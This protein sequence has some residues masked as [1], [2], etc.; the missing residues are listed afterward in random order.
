MAAAVVA[1]AVLG[2]TLAG[3]AAHAA[4]PSGGTVIRNVA[5]A[6]Y[7][8]AG[9]S[10]TETS[11]SNGVSATVLPVEALVL[12]QDQ[13]VSRPP[14]A[15]VTLSHLLAN[16][17]NVPSSYTIGLANGGAGCPAGALDMSALRVVRDTNNN[18][19]ADAADPVLP[20]GAG[21]AIAL[22]SGETA[23]LLVQG[24]VP[25]AASGNACVALT[26][27]TALQKL[28]AVNRDTVTVGDAAV[29]AITKSAS[30]PGFV[31]PGTTRIDFTGVVPV[32]LPAAKEMPSSRA[33]FSITGRLAP[34]LVTIQV[35]S[36]LRDTL[37]PALS[38]RF[39][40]MN[41]SLVAPENESVA[42]LATVPGVGARRDVGAIFSSGASRPSRI[43]SNETPI[44]R[45]SVQPALS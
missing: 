40:A 19:V 17:G 22:Q 26:A 30:Y 36:V 44:C 9:L 21:G 32:L 25:A 35:P 43:R 10:Q 20:L 2:C 5:T 38:S 33:A 3:T 45:A 7:V 12:T 28:S 6:T 11:S 1:M 34:L 37:A 13:S 18:G 29:L 4:P 8:P 31:V 42:P 14:A 16:T 15:V 41:A 24:T 23:A 39:T 27:T